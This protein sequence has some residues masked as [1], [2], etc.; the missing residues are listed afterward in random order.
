MTAPEAKRKRDLDVSLLENPSKTDDFLNEYLQ[1]DS[2]EP[3]K[4][5]LEPIK[6]KLKTNPPG[7]VKKTPRKVQTDK[8]LSEIPPGPHKFLGTIRVI[9]L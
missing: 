5:R 2:V 4:P 8:R 1:Q 6:I 3:K 9:H 7:T